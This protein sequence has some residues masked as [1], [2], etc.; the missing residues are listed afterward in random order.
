MDFLR[1]A[2]RLWLRRLAHPAVAGAAALTLLGIV[3]M[4]WVA[5]GVV[6]ARSDAA[7]RKA[8]DYDVLVRELDSTLH[9]VPMGR[10]LTTGQMLSHLQ[11]G[12]DLAVD[13]LVI[14]AD[15]TEVPAFQEAGFLHDEVRKF[16]RF[17]RWRA[18]AG[19]IRVEWYDSLARYNPSIFRTYVRSD[20]VSEVARSVAVHN[21]RV[22]SPFED[23]RWMTVTAR[24][25]GEGP[26]LLGPGVEVPLTRMSSVRVPVSGQ[27]RTCRFTP[28]PP[29]KPVTRV[30]I[31]C[32]S[33]LGE[34]VGGREQA[35]IHL[36]GSAV[37][38]LDAGYGRLRV[39]G[40]M[41]E[42]KTSRPMPP[43]T[44]IDLDPLGPT[45]FTRARHGVLAT[46]QWVNG[47]VRRVVEGPPGLRFL[48]LLG[49]RVDASLTRDNLAVRVSVDEPFSAELTDS[50]R[51][52]VEREHIPI[53]FASVVIADV[54]TGEILGIGETGRIAEPDR[55]R[56]MQPVNVGS[57]VKPILAAA[58]LSQRPALATLEVPAN[59]GSVSEIFGLPMGGFENDLHCAAPASGWV[60]LVFF[61]RCSNNRYAATLALASTMSGTA[62]A[63]HARAAPGAAPFR[64]AGQTWSGV[65]PPMSIGKGGIIP[66]DALVHSALA[67]GLLS[68]FDRVADP[69]ALGGLTRRSDVWAGLRTTAG[70]SVHAPR[71]IWPE[72]SQPTLVARGT[73]GTIP[74]LVAAYS[75]GAWENRWTL[76]D[77][78][79]A[80]VRLLADRAITLSFVPD[81][82]RRGPASQPP[83]RLGFAKARWYPLLTWGLTRVAADGTAGGL[84][85]VWRKQFGARRAVYAKTG[86]LSEKNDRIYVRTLAFGI[87]N[88]SP[89]T[90]AALG[91]GVVGTL[92]FKLTALPAGK[93]KIPAYHTNFAKEQLGPILARHWKRL[94]LCDPQ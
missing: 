85:D 32:R 81:G 3:P 43:G 38:T 34:N 72:V 91:C 93:D 63:A 51:A 23:T 52:I 78:T 61:I 84:R 68:S 67:S 18:E 44:I 66:Y 58:I 28:D 54:T 35:V 37:A 74:A 49:E 25:S 79:E 55:P 53:D 31:R 70:D 33:L 62:D 94:G 48:S 14:V 87:G 82:W 39:D 83:E 13:T 30:G 57:A 29:D 6:A 73:A 11:D 64:L 19:R 40:K 10:F 46:G 71:Q 65:R 89:K 59:G 86:T 20:S 76:I 5:W 27:P 8:L 36:D 24:E 45:V 4:L 77:L 60:D 69:E 41:L 17:Q 15:T 88:E 1:E 50:L 80:Y 47:R 90:G 92:Y 26:S 9:S 7:G 2:A 75:Y 22:P 42:P 21:L 12:A 56:F 16:N